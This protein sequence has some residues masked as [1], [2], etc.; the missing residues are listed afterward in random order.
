MADLTQSGSSTRL[1]IVVALI[2]NSL[3]AISKF[4]AAALTGSSAMLSE[5]IHSVV[6]IANELVLLYGMHRASARPDREHPLGFG[7]EVYFWSF[8]VALLIFTLGA[9]VSIY[10]GVIHILNPHI[11]EDANVSYIVLALA[12]LFEGTSWTVT[13]RKFKGKRKYSDLFKLIIRSKDPPT[14]IVLLEDSAALIGIAIA[15]MGIYL[16][17]HLNQPMLDGVASIFIG[18]VLGLTAT[19]LARETKGLLIGE[20]ANEDTRDSILKLATEI[21]GIAN[22]NDVLSVHVA[23]REILVAL[24]IEFE[25]RLRT[26]EIEALVIEL[27]RRIRVKHPAVIAVFVKP[28]TSGRFE[29]DPA[30]RSPSG[31]LGT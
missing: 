25:D 6:D 22:A 30:G 28:Q 21:E 16:S 2:G 8:V 18:I 14:F 3:V 4:A 31:H 10:E 19:V 7:R 17:I 26:P 12:L 15:F 1:V 5:G 23:P 27:E 20:S 13:L 29:R 24:S 9:G 11:I